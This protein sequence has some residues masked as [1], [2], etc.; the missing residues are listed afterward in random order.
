MKKTRPYKSDALA[1]IHETMSDMYA[2]GGIDKKTMLE[3]DESCLTSVQ[4]LSAEEIK[5]IPEHEAVSQTVFALY[6]NVSKESVSQWERGQKKPAGTT[7]KL[8][9]LVK[10][11]GLA[12]IA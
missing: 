2:S 12:S 1:A 8:L 11:K 4:E 3:F 5:A 7:L 9:S 6:L 10:K